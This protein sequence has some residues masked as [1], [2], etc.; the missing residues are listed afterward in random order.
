MSTRLRV[1]FEGVSIQISFVDA[2]RIREVMSERMLGVKETS[3][4]CAA[5]TLVKYRWVPP[6]TSDTLTTWEP[7]ARD[8]RIVAVVAEPDEKARAYR[9]CSKAAIAV[10]KFCLFGFEERVYS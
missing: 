6:Y 3:T 4:P 2:G 7:W 10:S 8:C 9:A 1:G 5:A